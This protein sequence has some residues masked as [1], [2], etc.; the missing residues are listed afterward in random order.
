MHVEMYSVLSQVIL[1]E[2]LSSDLIEL[3][4]NFVQFWS[5][6]R[7]KLLEYHPKTQRANKNITT[8]HLQISEIGHKLDDKVHALVL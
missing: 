5:L 8:T 6:V 7:L 2:S 1:R 3:G 4:K